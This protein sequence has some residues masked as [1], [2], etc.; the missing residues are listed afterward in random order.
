MKI[1]HRPAK[2]I[3]RRNDCTVGHRF[4]KISDGQRRSFGSSYATVNNEFHNPVN[5]CRVDNSSGPLAPTWCSGST[6][7]IGFHGG[8]TSMRWFKQS[9]D[10]PLKSARIQ[11]QLVSN[12]PINSTSLSPM[13]WV[14]SAS[15]SAPNSPLRTTKMH[16]HAPITKPYGMPAKSVYKYINRESIANQQRGYNFIIYVHIWLYTFFYVYKSLHCNNNYNH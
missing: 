15:N 5:L 12:R 10:S 9:L 2:R 7:P 14:N 3:P 13:K 16:R 6:Q 8:T 11:G 4:R 1:D